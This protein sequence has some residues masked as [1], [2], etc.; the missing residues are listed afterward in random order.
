M[1]AISITAVLVALSLGMAQ[2]QVT[3]T[4]LVPSDGRPGN[5]FGASI[6]IDGD[7]LIVGAP[8]TAF[9]IGAAYIFKRTESGW[10]E[11]A[12]LTASDG[13]TGEDFDDFGS[14]V[15]LD[16]DYAVIGATQVILPPAFPDDKGAAYVFARTD[17][18]WVEQEKLTPANPKVGDHFGYA[19]WLSGDQVIIGAAGAGQVGERSK[20]A[21]YIFERQGNGWALATKLTASDAIEGQRLGRSVWLSD[22]E[23]FVGA[24]STGETYVFRREGNVWQEQA[25][26]TPS[27][28]SRG[29]IFGDAVDVAGDRALIGSPGWSDGKGKAYVFAR[30]QSGW[31]EQADILASTGDSEAGDRFGEAVA[32]SG[33]Y[34]LLGASHRNKPPGE[35]EPGAAYLFMRTE[36]GWEE[37]LKLTPSDAKAGDT[38]GWSVRFS[39]PYAV[40]G[41]PAIETGASGGAVY[42]YDL[43]TVVSV[44]EPLSGVPE[45]FGLEQN[46]PNPFNPNTVIRYQLPSSSQVELTI[47]NAVGQRIKTLVSEKQAVGSYQIEWDGTDEK[48]TSVASGVY[49]YRLQA[50]EFVQSKKMTLTR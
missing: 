22:V 27:D 40:I 39:G 11:E 33:D 31:I 46:Y 9:N 19:T 38:F 50:G 21:A 23:A 3:E 35:E 49:L 8:G 6:A 15:A 18:G 4:K 30:T 47:Y 42:I 37:Q 1:K 28:G 36:T 17:A 13:A 34:A 7:Y 44:R 48:G 43:S 5:K 16:G 32:L 25:K 26:L 41:A 24:P 20:G 2:A 45:T 10:V 14:S 29:N 12:K